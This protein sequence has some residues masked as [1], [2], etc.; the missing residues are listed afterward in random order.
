M[1]KTQKAEIIE[2]LSTDFKN[3]QAVIF[4]DY[5]GLSVSDLEGLR[6]IARAKEA[7][8]QVV[9][10]TLATIAL[11]KADLTGVEL[12]D[13]NILVWGEDSVATSKVVSEFAKDN[14][15]FIIKSAYV[16][17]EVS[18]AT[19]VEAFAKL[20]GRDELLGMLAATWMAPLTCIGFG[21]NALKE[22]KEQEEAA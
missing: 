6:K 4:C 22:K 7:K 15:K 1:T 9:K 14:E 18:D 2:V 13:T 3:A 19:K 8:V 10:N 21:L 12:K 17:R 16:D 11:E 20:P 5:K